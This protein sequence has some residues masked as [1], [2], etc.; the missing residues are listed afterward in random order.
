M[1][2]LI[3]H[4][5]LLCRY[6]SFDDSALPAA[7]GSRVGSATARDS[8]SNL[9]SSFKR[10]SEEFGRRSPQAAY[11]RHSGSSYGRSSGGSV[12]GRDSGGRPEAARYAPQGGG[13]KQD[14]AD[15]GV[16][17]VPDLRAIARAAAA[18]QAAESAALAAR[19]EAA[20]ASARPPAAQQDKATGSSGSAVASGDAA[21]VAAKQQSTRSDSLSP[22]PTPLVAGV[23]LQVRCHTRQP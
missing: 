9:Y 7:P 22:P 13:R 4:R 15:K 17:A 19:Q 8:M 11:G 14:I 12:L 3:V 20:E 5:D 2:P 6:G 21:P 16:D 10:D 1:S 23:K 18:M